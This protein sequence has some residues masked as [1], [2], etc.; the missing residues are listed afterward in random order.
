MLPRLTRITSRIVSRASKSAPNAAS[1][2]A[3]VASE[4]STST[5]SSA[6]NSFWTT[7]TRYLAPTFL[8]AL[9]RIARK[10]CSTWVAGFAVGIGLIGGA[11]PSDGVCL[12][13]SAT[14]CRPTRSALDRLISRAS[15]RARSANRVRCIS[16]QIVP[17]PSIACP[18]VGALI[19]GARSAPRNTLR[20]MTVTSGARRLA[21][22]TAGIASAASAATPAKNR[23]LE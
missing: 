10:S 9:R 14:S 12:R 2:P 13:H 6:S 4:P 1:G 23:A 17:A 19:A 22:A 16:F 8:S 15:G 3:P 7:T 5:G 11:P 21:S 20:V 18:I